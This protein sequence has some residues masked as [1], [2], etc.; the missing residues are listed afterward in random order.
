MLDN[1]SM[2]GRGYMGSQFQGTQLGMTR[3]AWWH[4]GI[5]SAS[6]VR[7]WGERRADA[8]CTVSFYLAQKPS[9]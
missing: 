9:L 3:K 1:D 5:H 6:T 7:K 2:R 8:Q 4:N